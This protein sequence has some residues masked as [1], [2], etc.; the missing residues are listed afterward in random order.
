MVSSIDFNHKQDAFKTPPLS[1][2][3]L[4]V[5]AWRRAIAYLSETDQDACAVVSKQL[6][7]L[8]LSDPTAGLEAMDKRKKTI[9][10]YNPIPSEFRGSTQGPTGRFLFDHPRSKDLRIQNIHQKIKDRMGGDPTFDQTMKKV[11]EI[12]HAHP[13]YIPLYHG[14][15]L[16]LM[17]FMSLTR[18]L[19]S[20][21]YI[22]GMETFPCSNPMIR[23]PSPDGPKTIG[24]ALSEFPPNFDDVIETVRNELLACNPSLFANFDINGEST[25]DYY[26]SNR[27][28]TPFRIQS[29][30]QNLCKSYQIKPHQK[31]LDQLEVLH[32]ELYRLAITYV[33]QNMPSPSHYLAIEGML[34]QILIPARVLDKIAY[35]SVAYGEIQKNDKSLLE[36]CLTLRNDPD[37]QPL[38]QV[39]LLA[40]SILINGYGIKVF[41]H[42]CGGF[43]DEHGITDKPKR[44]TDKQWAIQTNCLARKE[45]ILKEAR[46]IF[47]KMILLSP[48]KTKK[49][50]DIQPSTVIA[51]KTILL[52]Y[53]LLQKKASMALPPGFS[54]R[55]YYNEHNLLEKVIQTDPEGNETIYLPAAP[56]PV[57]VT[58]EKF[59]KLLSWCSNSR[60]RCFNDNLGKPVK[61]L[62]ISLHEDQEDTIY[63]YS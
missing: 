6:A 46:E 58:K 37:S 18:A 52:N 42:C 16:E 8:V 33:E 34:L 45:E 63:S 59:D 2:N 21:P 47:T 32:T 57:S 7:I 17:V 4:P 41:A 19:L 12:E 13:D 40:Q 22:P 30:L 24:E 5:R 14:G 35:A 49:S 48:K 3:I 50:T 15:S 9:L 39:R 53:A 62:E 20:T 23:F 54:L 36:R 27:S 11:C 55:P 29:F 38:M 31:Y 25:W 44:M 43:F 60:Y 61:I 1:A 10:N 51:P 26:L 28:C 56:K